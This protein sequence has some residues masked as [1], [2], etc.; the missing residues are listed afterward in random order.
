MIGINPAVFWEMSI[1]EITLAIKGFSE[2]NGGSKD[3]PMSKDELEELRERY[4]D[5]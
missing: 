1:T 2:L 3:K 5:Y 4:P